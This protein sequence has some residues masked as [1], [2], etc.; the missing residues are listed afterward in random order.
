[1]ILK[2]ADAT[3]AAGRILAPYIGPGDV[4]ALSGDLGVGKTCFVRG[5]LAG[6]GFDGEAPSPSFACTGHPLRAAFCS[7]S[8]LSCRSL[9]AQD[10]RGSRGTWP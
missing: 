2:D 7:D 3:E 6:L 1:M 4:V 10:V 8:R 5:L 9:S